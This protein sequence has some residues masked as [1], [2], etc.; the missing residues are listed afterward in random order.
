MSVCQK[1]KD[2]FVKTKSYFKH[3]VLSVSSFSPYPLPEYWMIVFLEN[4]ISI[5]IILTAFKFK[6]KKKFNSYKISQCPER[7][8]EGKLQ[9]FC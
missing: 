2:V 3:H 5:W 9:S 1:K 6:V 7:D 4:T 8:C